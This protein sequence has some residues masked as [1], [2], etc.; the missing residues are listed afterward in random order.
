MKKGATTRQKVV[1][2][3]NGPPWI[4]SGL[5]EVAGQDQRV[6]R[7]ALF[8]VI[9]SCSAPRSPPAAKRGRSRTQLRSFD[10]VLGRFNRND[11]KEGTTLFVIV[12]LFAVQTLL[13]WVR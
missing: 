8:G 5:E 1:L 10:A 2:G 3:G 4:D 7:L 11:H 6:R 9:I 13:S 12:A